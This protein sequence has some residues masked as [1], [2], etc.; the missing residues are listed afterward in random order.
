M[1]HSSSTAA[2]SLDSRSFLRAAPSSSSSPLP[3]PADLSAAA[4]FPLPLPLDT[5]LPAGEHLRSLSSAAA[6]LASRSAAA[7]MTALPGW[8][9]LG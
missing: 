9:K 3:L 7:G 5:G 6:G 1:K 4:R 2:W 8:Q